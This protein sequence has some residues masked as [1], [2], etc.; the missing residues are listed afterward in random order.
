MSEV[1]REPQCLLL[2]VSVVR[3]RL[4]V[5]ILN[6]PPATGITLYHIRESTSSIWKNN[7]SSCQRDFL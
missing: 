6:V 5:G 3:A 4:V 7:R 1:Q 2:Q